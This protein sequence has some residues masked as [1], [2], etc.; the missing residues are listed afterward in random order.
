MNLA[1]LLSRVFAP[2]PRVIRPW[3]P[4]LASMLTDLSIRYPLASLIYKLMTTVFASV[5]TEDLTDDPVLRATLLEF[6]DAAIARCRAY[7]DELQLLRA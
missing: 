2:N 5:G 1:G 3:A 4:L 6:N 7:S